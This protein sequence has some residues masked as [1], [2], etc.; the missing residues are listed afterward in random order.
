M[1]DS[2]T[3][4]TNLADFKNYNNSYSLNNLKKNNQHK[5]YS[6]HKSYQTKNVFK[7]C[8]TA[9]IKSPIYQFEKNNLNTEMNLSD[10]D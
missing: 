6:N 9:N 10:N 1:T 4:L 5:F 2:K 8:K 7:K 3:N